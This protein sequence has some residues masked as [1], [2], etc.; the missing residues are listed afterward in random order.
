MSDLLQMQRVDQTTLRLVGEF[1]IS[2]ADNV[3][4]G[5]LEF[6]RR[7]S[8]TDLTLDLSELCFI[9]CSGIRCLLQTAAALD[10][11]GALI[12]LR[13]RASVLR[14]LEMLRIQDALN[15]EI[16]AAGKDEPAP[17]QEDAMFCRS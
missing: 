5:L 17:Y 3:Q 4:S 15:L 6:A 1:D 11:E 14:L 9:D 2:S 10:D 8:A 16:R 12:L 7:S 13:P